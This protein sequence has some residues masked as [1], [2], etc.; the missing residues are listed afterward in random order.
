MYR[1]QAIAVSYNRDSGRT[2]GGDTVPRLRIK[3][4]ADDQGLNISQLQR[5]AN[6]TYST[7]RRYY[8]NTRDGKTQGEPLEELNLPVLIAI[9]EV[10]GVKVRDLLTDDRQARYSAAA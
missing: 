9:A 6:I 1:G 7:A 8:Y 2:K 10:L 4:L 5:R 3:E